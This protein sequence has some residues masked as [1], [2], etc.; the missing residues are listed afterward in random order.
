MGFIVSQSDTGLFVKYDR[1]D[2]ISLLLYVDDIILT[3]SSPEKVQT[4]IQELRDV[5]DLKDMG[6]LSYFLGLEVKYKANGD[7]FHS[8]S[9]YA[10]DLLHKASMDSCK[11]VNT[12]CRPHTQ[13]LD[14]EGI[15]LSDPTL[16]RSLVGVLQYLTFT[17]PNLAYVVNAACQYM[18]NPTDVHSDMV[19]I[20]LRYMQGTINYSLTYSTSAV[21]Q[22][23]LPCQL[24]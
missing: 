13:F 11:C 16:C 20:I 14:S 9:K 4:I 7:I 2:V 21:L 5:F 6:K 1:V 10:K 8:Q 3:G 17:R 12:S 23:V 24:I 22:W 18:N 19:K 15:P